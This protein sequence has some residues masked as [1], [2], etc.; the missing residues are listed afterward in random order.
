MDFKKSEGLRSCQRGSLDPSEWAL[1]ALFFLFMAS[2]VIVSKVSVYRSTDLIGQISEI[3]E[4]IFV[5]LSG[6]VKKPG[7]YRVSAGTTLGVVLRRAQ[8]S[9]YADLGSLPLEDILLKSAHF[10][11]KELQEICVKIKGAV[12]QPVLLT[13]PIGSKIS[14]LKSK[15]VLTSEADRVFLKSR[16]KLRNGD[17]IVVPKKAVERN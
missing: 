16:K 8:P 1:L 17:E 7:V 12:L 5:T 10:N 2:L 4:D 9:F 13:L 6:A 15:I 11:V 14:D 3:S